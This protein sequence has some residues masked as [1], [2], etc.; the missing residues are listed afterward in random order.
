MRCILAQ[1]WLR[2]LIDSFLMRFP[3]LRNMLIQVAAGSGLIEYPQQILESDYLRK[4]GI[5]SDFNKMS[6]SAKRIYFD[7]NKAIEKQRIEK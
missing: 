2:S 5:Y 3:L 7:L 4:H 1:F 6:D